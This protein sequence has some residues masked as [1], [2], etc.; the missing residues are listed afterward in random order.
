MIGE[1]RGENLRLCFQPAESAGMDD[2]VAVARI[3]IAI[4]MRGFRVTPARANGARP[5]RKKRVALLSV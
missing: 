4:G 3:V 5:S 1:A 2:A